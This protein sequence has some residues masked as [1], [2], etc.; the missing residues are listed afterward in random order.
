MKDE[1]ESFHIR[2][3]LKEYASSSGGFRS[4]AMTFKL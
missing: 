4:A 2:W 3:L 1:P